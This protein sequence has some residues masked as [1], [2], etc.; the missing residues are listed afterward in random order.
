MTIISSYL[1]CV[2]TPLRASY[3]LD[4][5]LKQAYFRGEKDLGDCA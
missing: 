5:I 4:C 3:D 1:S 2:L